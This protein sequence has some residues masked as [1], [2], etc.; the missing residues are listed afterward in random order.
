MPGAKAATERLGRCADPDAGLVAARVHALGR[1]REHDVGA[2]RVELGDVGLEIARVSGEIFVGPELRGVDEDGGG[3][4][5]GA[6]LGLAHQR[7]VSVVQRAHRRHEPD[8]QP[9]VAS[10]GAGLE[11]CP[12]L[13]EDPDHGAE[14][15]PSSVQRLRAY[16]QAC[17]STC[18]CGPVPP[19]SWNTN[20]KLA[21][22]AADSY[23]SDMSAAA[24]H[25]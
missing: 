9:R 5:A 20:G 15:T 3:D 10:A 25:M 24:P 18:R 22:F 4:E 8:A 2:G 6:A 7:Q 17:M 19:F 14:P 23:M 21:W 13:G 11:E 1:R 16:W 12:R